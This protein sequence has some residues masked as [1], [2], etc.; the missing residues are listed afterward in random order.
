MQTVSEVVI[1]RPCGNLPIER[2]PLMTNEA[3]LP[4]EPREAPIMAGQM[5]AGD[6]LDAL[7]LKLG[8]AVLRVCPPSLADQRDDLVHNALLRVIE[9]QRRDRGQ[10]QFNASYLWKVAYSALV[11]ELRRRRRRGEVSLEEQDQAVPLP[12]DRRSDPGTQAAVRELGRGIQSCL[13]RLIVPRRR[14]VTLYLQGYSVQQAASLL[15]WP[16]K[17]TENLIYRGLENLRQCLT[18]RG[19]RP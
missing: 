8:R 1:D 5:I 7:R 16:A 2:K 3:T 6:D 18:Q 9:V 4:D 11:D 19:L 12:A 15:D 10:R 13:T 17:R 14:A